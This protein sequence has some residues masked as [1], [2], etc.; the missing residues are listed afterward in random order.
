MRIIPPRLL[1]AFAIPAFLAW[2]CLAWS[3]DS[4]LESLSTPADREAAEFIRHFPVIR[5]GITPA[6]G[7]GHQAYAVSAMKR[8]RELGFTG[9]FE[10]YYKPRVKPKLEYLIPGFRAD[11]PSIQELPA[12]GGVTLVEWTRPLDDPSLAERPKVALGVMGGDDSAIAPEDLGVDALIRIQ[13]TGWAAGSVALAGQDRKNWRFLDEASELPTYVKKPDLASTR[14][15]LEAEMGHSPNLAAKLPGLKALFEHLPGVEMM[16][17]YGLSYMNGPDKLSN[18]LIAIQMAR[19][20]HPE[21]FKGPV[22]VPLLSSFDEEEW[23]AFKKGVAR[24]PKLQNA[25]KIQESSHPRIAKTFASLKQEEILV[26]PVGAV[27]QGIWNSLIGLSSLPPTVAGTTGT[28]FAKSMGRP[29]L[30]T[31][32]GEKLFQDS[33]HLI[34]EKT[35]G[36]VR[37]ANSRLLETGRII[38]PIENHFASLAT[39]MADSL[40]PGSEVSLAFAKAEESRRARTDKVS[41]TLNVAKEHFMKGTPP[42]S[43]GTDTAPADAASAYRGGCLRSVLDKLRSL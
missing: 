33:V 31:V 9:H 27:T 23:N 13:P 20:R 41:A 12:F 15:S 18:A 37:D 19:E 17:A 22:V 5:I 25:L 7:N 2:S 38:G 8:L 10:V 14:A 3:N 32:K 34:P 42:V 6:P 29:F 24:Y 16:A 40:D 36:S 28:N 35:V 4:A 39:F 30:R 1:R 26:M 43:A 21:R 11:G